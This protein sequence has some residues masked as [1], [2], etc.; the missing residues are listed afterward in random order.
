MGETTEFH[1]VK[2]G[3]IM[4]VELEPTAL[5]GEFV[6]TWISPEFEDQ[7]DLEDVQDMDGIQCPDCKAITFALRP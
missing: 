6:A 7:D 4:D 2:C 3:T 5:R 1:C